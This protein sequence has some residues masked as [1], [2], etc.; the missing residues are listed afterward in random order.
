[1]SDAIQKIRE[2]EKFGSILGLERMNMLMEKLGN[3]QDGMK[4]IHVAGTNG[5][6]SVCRFVYEILRENGYKAGIYTSPYI[7][8]FNERIE[9]DGSYITDEDLQVCTNEVLEKV[10]ELTDA[11][12]DSPTEFEVVTAVAFL[13]FSKKN[14]DYIVL[15]VGL[16][17]RGD[18]TN[19]I[20]DPLVSVI[21]AIS[22]DHMD[23]LGNTI[24][25]IA[26]EKAGIIKEGRPV[27]SN[28]NNSKAT[29][30]MKNVAKGLNAPL[31]DVTNLKRGNIK[32][33]AGSYVF[34]AEINGTKYDGVEISMIGDH[35]IENAL[36]ALTAIEI[37]RT[38]DLVKLEKEK[39]YSGLKKARQ[40]ARFEILKEKPFFIIDGAHNEQGAE[41][42]KKTMQEHFADRKV[43][44]ITGMLADK[45]VDAIL[46][47][48]CEIADDFIVTEPKNDRKLPAEVLR[49]QIVSAG[50][51]CFAIPDPVEAC[52]EALKL[53]DKYDV[54]LCAGS[55]YM[56][57]T[58]RSVLLS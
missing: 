46:G 12:F 11:G 44:M 16:G 45:D 2:F 50:K 23:R 35:Q 51:N 1:M 32:K 13:Y 8:E 19:I 3:P 9:F 52:K 7:V 48:F 14:A 38:N 54:I 15:E 47:H 31:Y 30:V 53:K 25:L 26:G 24:E 33:A 39:I 5:K 28:T 27:A 43:L 6:G 20:K 29:E 21:T 18:S 56:L 34:D 10:K 58:V 49:K 4:F 57:G 55:L 22:F 42:L 40:I 36:S 37:L 41:V 17:G